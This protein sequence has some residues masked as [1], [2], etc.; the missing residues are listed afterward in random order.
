MAARPSRLPCT[1]PSTYARP[2]PSILVTC[3]QN[4]RCF[5]GV[6]KALGIVVTRAQDKGKTP[7][8]FVGNGGQDKRVIGLEPTT[9]TLAT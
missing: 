9:F 5:W 1:K 8:S 3:W 2:R 7:L 4:E 6:G